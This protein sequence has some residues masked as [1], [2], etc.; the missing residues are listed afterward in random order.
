MYTIK[1]FVDG[2]EY[3][4]HNPRV[5]NLM[6]GDPYFE[7]GDNVN[8]QAEFSV[9]PTHPFYK[10]VKKLTTDVVFYKDG[11][12]VFAGRVLY[13]DEELN[14]TKKVFVEGELAYLCD[15]VQRQA[16]Y[17]NIS[18]VNYLKA[19]LDKHNSQ[20]EKRK[21]FALGRVS[22]TDPNNSLYRY[23]NY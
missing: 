13:D 9:Y 17:H 8:G 23:S 19:I 22:V 20:V 11:T 7:V 2:K 15:S 14:G 4:L 10:Y 21:Q 5:K 18:V 1:A 3:M 6:V 16:V 12:E